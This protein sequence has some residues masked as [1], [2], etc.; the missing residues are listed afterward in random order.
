[1]IRQP[2]ESR[3]KRALKVFNYIYRNVFGLATGDEFDKLTNDFANMHAQLDGIKDASIQHYKHMKTFATIVDKEFSHIKKHIDHTDQALDLLT[4][5][6][7]GDA[8]YIDRQHMLSLSMQRDIYTN[9]ALQTYMMKLEN[10]YSYVNTGKLPPFLV[11]DGY[12][13]SIFRNINHRLARTGSEMRVPTLS[14]HSIYTD[15]KVYWTRIG[16]DVLLTLNIPIAE[17]NY[18]YS[19]YKID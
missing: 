11:S 9:V 18:K 15:L 14:P 3:S 10:I 17:L 1:M 7:T 6:T 19:L 13:K 5:I 2:H 12:L 8:H 16:S 4:N